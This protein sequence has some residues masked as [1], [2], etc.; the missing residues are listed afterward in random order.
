M[1]LPFACVAVIQNPLN[2]D[3][4]LTVTR[5]NDPNDVG[6]PGGKREAN[7]TPEECLIRELEEEAGIFATEMFFL[8][9]GRDAHEHL[10][11]AYVV[12]AWT[13]TPHTVE[14]GVVAGYVAAD[15]LTHPRQ[16]FADYN[17]ACIRTLVA[18]QPV[19]GCNAKGPGH[20]RCGLPEH[21]EGTPHQD[22]QGKF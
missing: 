21:P 12:T 11:D 22:S 2:P 7:E 16:S 1:P 9:R 19:R 6:F 18:M 3:E 8:F 17:R 10:V 4:Y 13:G 5:R 15:A 14:P 20:R